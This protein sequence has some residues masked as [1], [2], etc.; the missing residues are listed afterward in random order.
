MKPIAYT[1]HGQGTRPVLVAERFSLL[2]CLFAPLW[3]LAHQAWLHF[4]LY[5]LLA[6]VAVYVQML[7]A[8]GVAVVAGLLVAAHLFVGFEAGEF[9]RSALSRRGL[10]LLGVVCAP[11]EAEAVDRLV[12]RAR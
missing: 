3:L 10:A 5:V 4:G 1:V 8:P 7:L 2:A 6:G 9:R 12:L 11:D